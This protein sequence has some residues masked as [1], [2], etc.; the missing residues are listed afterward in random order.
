M[1]ILIILVGKPDKK[2]QQK[3]ADKGGNKKGKNKLNLNLENFFLIFSEAADDIYNWRIS[4]SL[5]TLV[6]MD[7]VDV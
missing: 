2:Q 7:V 3:G 4:L 6:K 5:S 1:T